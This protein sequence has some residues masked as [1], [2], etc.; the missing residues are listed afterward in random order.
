[1]ADITV[2]IQD[3]TFSGGTFVTSSRWCLGTPLFL[4]PRLVTLAAS[5]SR[6]GTPLA[7]PRL[8]WR[9]ATSLPRRRAGLVLA[10]PSL[11][12]LVIRSSW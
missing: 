9:L 4:P 2:A 12:L 11:W 5:S 1:M 8:L 7:G 6:C 10:L 3:A